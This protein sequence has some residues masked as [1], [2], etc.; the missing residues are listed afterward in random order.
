MNLSSCG[1][2]RDACKFRTEMNCAGCCAVKG[3]PFWANGKTCDLFACAS[4]KGLR[5]CGECADFPC[6]TLTEWANTEPG[7]NGRRIRN[8]RTRNA[9]R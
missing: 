2:D 8:L 3:Q 6:K 9:S 7:E 4:G 1:I 5:D